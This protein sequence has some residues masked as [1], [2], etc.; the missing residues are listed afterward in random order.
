MI[1]EKGI[2]ILIDTFAQLRDEGRTDIT[3]DIWGEGRDGPL[4]AA[5]VLERD[6][7][8]VFRFRGVAPQEV[9]LPELGSYDVMVFPTY[10]REPFGFAPLE[11]AARGCVPL[12]SAGCGIT[13]WLVDGV[14]LLT[15]PRDASSF[16]E[17]LRKVLGGAVDLPS[18][19]RRGQAIALGDFHIDVIAPR[20]EAILA[21]A[22]ERRTQ[23][24]LS[25][26]EIGRLARIA[27]VLADR[28]VA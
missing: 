26:L 22:I 19:G 21:D 4:M 6:L 8:G 25:W 10:L 3:I 15:A 2:G 27:E 18:I 14:H 7:S 23:A 16:A 20:V 17:A 13:E 1:E 5:R 12:V 28:L 11:A 9:L 24:P